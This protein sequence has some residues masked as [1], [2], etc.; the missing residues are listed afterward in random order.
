MFIAAAAL[1]PMVLGTG[2]E[3]ALRAFVERHY[4]LAILHDSGEGEFPRLLAAIRSIQTAKDN[5]LVMVTQEALEKLRTTV[6]AFLPVIERLP[7]PGA[8]TFSCQLQGVCSSGRMAGC[9]FG[10][11][12]R[13]SAPG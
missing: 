11:R 12:T 8:R 1:V 6:P 5:R 13:R 2:Y 4:G 3:L 9:R 7:K 10:S